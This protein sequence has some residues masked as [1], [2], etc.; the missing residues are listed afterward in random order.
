MKFWITFVLCLFSALLFALI[1]PFSSTLVVSGILLA[2]ALGIVVNKKVH[3]LL[4]IV[5]SVDLCLIA[6][7]LSAAWGTING[8]AIYYNIVVEG[9]IA[10]VLSFV[11]IK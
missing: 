3:P 6:A 11:P 5:I 2:A 1:N 7:I 10:S 9:L 8:D 4:T